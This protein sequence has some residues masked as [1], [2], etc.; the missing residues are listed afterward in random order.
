MKLTDEQLEQVRE[1]ARGEAKA[2]VAEYA[3]GGKTSEDE[4][5]AGRRLIDPPREKGNPWRDI[6]QVY[7]G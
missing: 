6:N 1:I 7:E 5:N 4:V 2:A 3:T